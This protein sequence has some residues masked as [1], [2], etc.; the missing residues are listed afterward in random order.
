M[1]EKVALTHWQ[2]LS[3]RKVKVQWT[4]LGLCITYAQLMEDALRDARAKL[5][6]VKFRPLA[7]ETNETC[8]SSCVAR[9]CYKVSQRWRTEDTPCHAVEHCVVN[10]GYTRSLP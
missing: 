9:S 5:G 6:D 4:E 3:L 8:Q 7:H 2:E 10:R 1:C